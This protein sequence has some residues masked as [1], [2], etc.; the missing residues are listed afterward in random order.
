MQAETLAGLDTLLLFAGE[1]QR[2]G[3]AGVGR[4]TEGL[5]ERV[6][7]APQGA[8]HTKLHSKTLPSPVA[9]SNKEPT[10]SQLWKNSTLCLQVDQA[11]TW[12]LTLAVSVALVG[13]SQFL[14]A[15]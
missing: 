2:A 10:P 8:V 12:P 3:E 7:L 9:D 5:G 15:P 13:S 11:F 1:E 14:W 4:R 6:R